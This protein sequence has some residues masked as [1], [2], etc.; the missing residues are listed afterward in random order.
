[1]N[2][3]DENIPESQRQLLR[4]WR[5]PARQIGLDAEQ[6]GIKDREIIPYLLQLRRVTFFTLDSDFYRRDLRH[7]RYCLVC[8]DVN[9][10]E[11]AAFIRRVLNRPEFTA[12]AQ[13]MGAV[14]RVSSSGLVVWRLRAEK[15]TRL[16][17]SN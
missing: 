4:G 3:L 8:L 11:A 10:Q 15:E 14:M 1:M 7:P 5:I 13:R 2:L 9:K 12:A 17:W 16:N 6:K